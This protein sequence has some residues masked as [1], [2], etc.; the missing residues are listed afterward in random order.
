VLRALAYIPS[1]CIHFENIAKI[2]GFLEKLVDLPNDNLFYMDGKPWWLDFIKMPD[3]LS[4]LAGFLTDNEAGRQAAADELIRCL[5]LEVP[6]GIELSKLLLREVLGESYAR[7]KAAE[8]M[9][10]LIPKVDAAGS[11]QAEAT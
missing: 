11:Q 2:P 7:R 4:K 6:P 5:K 3:S 10:K 1:V 9:F 8:I